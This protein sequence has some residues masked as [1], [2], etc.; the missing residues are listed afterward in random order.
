MDPSFD[1]GLCSEDVFSSK[2]M[3][4]DG[5]CHKNVFPLTVPYI[6]C[7]FNPVLVECF[8]NSYLRNSQDFDTF[9]NNFPTG[10]YQLECCPFRFFFVD[11][12]LAI[13]IRYLG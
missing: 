5:L 4:E 6:A 2:S 9:S 11:I 8:R 1:V 12:N 10:F 3:I 7:E 13:S